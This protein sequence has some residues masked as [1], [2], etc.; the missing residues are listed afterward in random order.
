[1]SPKLQNRTIKIFIT[2][3]VMKQN[4]FLDLCRLHGGC[5]LEELHTRTY[6]RTFFFFSPTSQPLIC[7]DNLA[8]NPRHTPSTLQTWAFTVVIGS[9]GDVRKSLNFFSD[10]SSKS[11]VRVSHSFG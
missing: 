11:S 7:H 4:D 10:Q 9:V 5:D 3:K 2:F 6:R 1:M 8:A